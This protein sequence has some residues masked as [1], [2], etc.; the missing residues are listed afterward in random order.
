MQFSWDPIA[1]VRHR[2]HSQ[3]GPG[4]HFSACDA[5]LLAARVAVL[6]AAAAGGLACSYHWRR[7]YERE[8]VGVPTLIHRPD[9]VHS[10]ALQHCSLLNEEYRPTF[11]MS[12][13]HAQSLLGALLRSKPD[14]TFARRL[15]ATS[16]GGQ[17]AIDTDTDSVGRDMDLGG[18]MCLMGLAYGAESVAQ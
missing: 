15:L 18:G 5:M 10:E 8:V 13:A 12:G 11:W 7:Y 14:I 4:I 16:D 6:T 17:L 9:A 3:T 1:K 2:H